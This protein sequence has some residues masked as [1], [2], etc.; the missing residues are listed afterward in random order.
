LTLDA[1]TDHQRGRHARYDGGAGQHGLRRLAVARA[2]QVDC[3]RRVCRRRPRKPQFGGALA[4]L[5]DRFGQALP[6]DPEERIERL[7]LDVELL[8]QRG[9]HTA[10]LGVTPAHADLFDVARRTASR[11]NEI[12]DGLHEPR[13]DVL[14][15]P[16]L[17][18]R[19]ELVD[20]SPPEIA[21]RHQRAAAQERDARRPFFERDEHLQCVR[22]PGFAPQPRE[23]TE[24]GGGR[25]HRPHANAGL[26]QRLKRSG[27]LRSRRQRDDDW[28]GRRTIGCPCRR[29]DVDPDTAGLHAGPVER[30]NRVGAHRFVRARR[31]HDLSM[32]ACGAPD[33]DRGPALPQRPELRLRVRARRRQHGKRP[34]VR[35][36]PPPLPGGGG[37]DFHDSAS[38]RRQFDS[39]SGRHHG[40]HA[41][42]A[43][44]RQVLPLICRFERGCAVVC[45]PCTRGITCLFN[46][47]RLLIRGRR[48]H[49]GR[50]ASASL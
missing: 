17:Q 7:E 27:Q 29:C 45:P 11:G 33:H 1:P 44:R 42:A 9:R 21:G 41:S 35:L 18:P 48:K 13:C 46:G 37:V 16:R 12:A 39:Y 4:K 24:C 2:E 19:A 14:A 32:L 20:V 26:Q 30:A 5:V 31:D 34:Y 36:P 23:R 15:A 8:H 38:I 22:R 49:P 28:P 43:P 50:F 6:I 3:R 40:N 25:H 47:R 10:Q